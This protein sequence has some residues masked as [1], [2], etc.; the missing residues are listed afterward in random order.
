MPDS[1]RQTHW[2]P[3]ALPLRRRW[4]VPPL[5]QAVKNHVGALRFT[6]HSA[7]LAYQ[8]GIQRLVSD[9]RSSSFRRTPM[10]WRFAAVDVDYCR[11][12]GLG[13]VGIPLR[14]RAHQVIAVRCP[15]EKGIDGQKFLASDA[16]YQ[17][18]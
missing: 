11:D 14:T 17:A 15:R 10:A 8:R 7:L 4:R 9:L 12:G 1:T 6:S 3:L 13:G 16:A 2:P 5:A 18:R